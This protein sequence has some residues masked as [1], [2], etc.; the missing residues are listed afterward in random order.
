MQLEQGPHAVHIRVRVRAFGSLRFRATP[1]P[2]GLALSPPAF[3][4]D[5][6]A[7]APLSGNRSCRAPSGG[8]CTPDQPPS[9]GSAAWGVAGHGW[10]A[11]PVQNTRLEAALEV[12]FAVEP[13]PSAP[14]GEPAAVALGLGR[15]A[16]LH[17]HS[18]TSY[19]IC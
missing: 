11:V 4:P 9:L 6:V 10:L 19:Q 17:Y 7:G 18:S 5:L 15:I 1:S 8:P 13:H 14:R 3:A 16:A 2:G 12:T